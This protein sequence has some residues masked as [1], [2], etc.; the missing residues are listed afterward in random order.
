MSAGGAFKGW[1]KTNKYFVAAH[2]IERYVLH[3]SNEVT[4][5]FACDIPQFSKL[6]PMK[7]N[8]IKSN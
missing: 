3:P 1:R 6:A 2:T 8:Q 5:L 7:P 4:T